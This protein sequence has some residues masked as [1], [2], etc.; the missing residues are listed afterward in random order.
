MFIE[1]IVDIK[2]NFVSSTWKRTL[3]ETLHLGDNGQARNFIRA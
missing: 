2:V 1:K 3:N